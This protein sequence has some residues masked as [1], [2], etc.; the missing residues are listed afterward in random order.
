[1]TP[2]PATFTRA[3]AVDDVPRGEGRQTIVDGRRIAIF[4]TPEGF[5]A[6]DAACP[7]RGGPLHD[8]ITA[9]ASVT[10]PLHLR[11]FDLVTGEAIGHDCPAVPAHAVEVRGNAIWVCVSGAGE[12]ALAA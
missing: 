5:R 2:L 3:C 4:R 12:G 6:L 10:C 11:R 1:M 7:H 8:G 9:D